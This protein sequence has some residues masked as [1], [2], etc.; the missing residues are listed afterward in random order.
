MIKKELIERSPLRILE[1]STHGGVKTGDIGVIAAPK[2]IGKTACLVHIATDQLFQDKHI[3]HVS[4]SENTN[5]ILTWYED[6]FTEISKECN[7]DNSSKIHD[8]LVRNR[9]IMNFNQDGIYIPQIKKRILL[10]IEKGNFSADT[11]VIDGYNIKISSPSELREF[12][13]FA[14]ELNLS[15]WF[16]F[17]TDINNENSGNSALTDIPEEFYSEISVIISLQPQKDFIH[18]NLVK[19]HDEEPVSDLHLKLDPKTLL[20]AR[21]N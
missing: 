15:L 8:E 14:K 9:I 20:I 7:L 18:L 10:L 21:E 17:D 5:H 2:G 3:I 6:I 1:N 16:S 11:I 13:E 4:F 12:K 19:D